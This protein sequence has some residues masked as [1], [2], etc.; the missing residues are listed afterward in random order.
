MY[1][2]KTTYEAVGQGQFCWCELTQLDHER[3]SDTGPKAVWV[4]DVGTV[5]KKSLLE[6]AMRRYDRETQGYK[7]N[8][9][10]V[11]H[12]DKDH[13]SGLVS[14]LQKFGAE[15]LVLPWMPVD[16]RVLI[17]LE[18][19]VSS[20]S[21][22]L[23]FILDP[24]GFIG[25][26][27]GDDV[28]EIYVV[29]PSGGDDPPTER[30]PEPILAGPEGQLS[31]NVPARRQSGFDDI[32]EDYGSAPAHIS[33]HQLDS[34]LSTDVAG[35]WE[36]LFYN[37]SATKPDDLQDFRRRAKQRVKPLLRT[38]NRDKLSAAFEEL[39]DFFD[40]E[41]GKSNRN[42]ASLFMY[43]GPF[44]AGSAQ[45]DLADISFGEFRNGSQRANG[46]MITFSVYLGENAYS[47][48]HLSC[49][50]GELATLAQWGDLEAYF[51]RKRVVGTLCTQIAHHG[52][53]NNWFDGL[54]GVM[55]PSLAV[56]SS[57]PTRKK[58][59][60]HVEVVGDFAKAGATVLRADTA[61]SVVI[62]TRLSLSRA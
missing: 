9:L 53:R 50:D 6:D 11:S 48:R 12:F 21:D 5:S 57:D 54:A 35:V 10:V 40:Q 16:E 30:G 23:S 33:F 59:H 47:A 31:F 15:K 27:F 1:R 55:R 18:Q 20:D 3:D 13:V 17:A 26:R 52:S 42:Q 61:Q 60:P 44:S 39:K 49:G 25:D 38:R 46:A 32:L 29:P 24:V 58:G 37:D 51:S 41:I 22:A 34:S 8:M 4:Y 45:W 19:D 56:F 14:F 7:P 28:S 2:Y 62:E 43:T 36:I